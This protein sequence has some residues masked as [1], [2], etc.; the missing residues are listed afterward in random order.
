MKKIILFVIPLALLLTACG[1]TGGKV[2]NLNVTDFAQKIS[3]KSV[4]VLDVRTPGEFQ[5]EHLENAINVDYEGSNFEGEV[6]KLDKSKTYAVYCRS[7]RRSGLA[8][9]IMAKDGFKS[10]FNLDGGIENWQAS[11]NKVVSK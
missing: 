4:V 9:E 11:G 1:T 7:G 2:T 6:Q 5:S 10:I 3:D 8:T